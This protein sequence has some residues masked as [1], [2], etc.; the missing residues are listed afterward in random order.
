MPP[1]YDLTN[2]RVRELMDTYG[3]DDPQTT[4]V[5]RTM[6]EL[7]VRENA[8]R[9]AFLDGKATSLIGFVGVMLALMVGQVA[10]WTT[11]MGAPERTLLLGAAISLLVAVM[12]AFRIVYA[13]VWRW[14]SDV[15]W[16][17]EE[18]LGKP[19]SLR[20]Y[21]IVVL[22]HVNE[23]HSRINSIKGLWLARAQVA[24]AF[25]SGLLALAV[26]SHL[27]PKLVAGLLCTATNSS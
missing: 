5:L 3:L 18:F 12:C 24:F 26:A 20:R 21:H 6:G 14:V 9:T 27:V 11:E 23:D 25:G 7:L 22:H 10:K 8:E 19:E 15:D 1:E 4:D 16:F 17:R 2:Q 13:G